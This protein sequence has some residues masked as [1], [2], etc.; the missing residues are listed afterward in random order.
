M[1]LTGKPIA[2]GRTA[3]IYAWEGN[4][5][6]KL[7]RP[8][9]PP[10]MILQEEYITDAIVA[11]GIVAPKTRGLIE[12]DGRPWA[13][14]QGKPSQRR[15]DEHEKD[16]PKGSRNERTDSADSQGRPCPPFTGHLVTIQARNHGASLSRNVN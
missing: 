12:V 9:F 14:V 2:E 4:C 11:A 3:E 1:E 6:L 15:G 8:G 16:D 10:G 7:L 5:I 13:E